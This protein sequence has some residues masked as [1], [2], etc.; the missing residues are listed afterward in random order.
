MQYYQNEYIALQFP[1]K[2]YNS[3]ERYLISMICENEN[4]N[5]NTAI[6]RY[7]EIISINNEKKRSTLET[8]LHNKINLLERL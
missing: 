4:C 7:N 1:E 3:F 2:I 8:N 6:E 5:L